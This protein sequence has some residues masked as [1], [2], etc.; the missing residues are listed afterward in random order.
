MMDF[1]AP[2]VQKLVNQLKK[3][4]T[5]KLQLQ[6]TQIQSTN[7]PINKLIQHEDVEKNNDREN[8]R[9][10]LPASQTTEKS[11]ESSET[12]FLA[13]T[14]TKSNIN[15]NVVE[16]KI[17][18][19]SGWFDRTLLRFGVVRKKLLVENGVNIQTINLTIK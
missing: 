11:V 1:F 9:L 19:P 4:K 18:C 17:I 15:M 3:E 5:E 14:N 2:H 12:N 7:L 10:P 8:I 13:N 16:E 6:E